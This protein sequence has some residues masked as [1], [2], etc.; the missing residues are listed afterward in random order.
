MP[1]KTIE[2]EGAVEWIGE[3]PCITLKTDPDG[4]LTTI[5]HFFRV[6]TSPK[7]AGIVAIVMQKPIADGSDDSES[8]ICV[9][10]NRELADYIIA[11]YAAQFG[12]FN[13]TDVT[14]RLTFKEMTGAHVR[15]DWP[16]EYTEVVEADGTKVEFIWTDI[17]DPIVAGYPAADSGIPGQTMVSTV[18]P[19]AG[20]AVVVNG[21]E[22]A[23]ELFEKETLGRKH[24]SS[25]LAFA[26]TWIREK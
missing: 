10:D 8:N 22:C 19:S 16:R 26:E 18:V 12:S 6:I 3:N 9:T 15:N 17:E 11:N 7:G 2:F 1:E 5:G 23:G 4:P 14:K 20:G 25:T 24:K 21:K 13:G